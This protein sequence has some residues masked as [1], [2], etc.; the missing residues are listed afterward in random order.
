MPIAAREYL[1]NEGVGDAESCKHLLESIKREMR[2][3]FSAHLESRRAGFQACILRD[4]DNADDEAVTNDEIDAH[5]DGT[6]P[7]VFVNITFDPERVDSAELTCVEQQF[8]L[9]LL[10]TAESDAKFY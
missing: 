8:Q 10:G 9:C 5:C 6:F 7:V 1:S 4:Y 3:T 2:R